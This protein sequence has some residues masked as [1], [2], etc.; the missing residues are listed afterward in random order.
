[1]N[2]AF[3]VG[4]IVEFATNCVRSPKCVEMELVREYVGNVFHARLPDGTILRVRSSELIRIRRPSDEVERVAVEAR[5]AQRKV[6]R[7]AREDRVERNKEEFAYMGKYRV[8]LT[9][10]GLPD[11]RCKPK[12][13]AKNA[14]QSIRARGRSNLP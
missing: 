7:D 3:T 10:K 11:K 4:D 6:E 13:S 14:P 8:R 9:A 5:K 12:F 2:F 1:M